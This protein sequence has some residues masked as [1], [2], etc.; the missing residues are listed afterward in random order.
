[1]LSAEDGSRAILLGGAHVDQVEVGLAQQSGQVLRGKA[2]R[3][4]IPLRRGLRDR[5]H[6]LC[7]AA[8]ESRRGR[9]QQAQ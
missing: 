5:W 6:G 9:Q 3:G 4:E 1:M 8:G 7:A 2:P